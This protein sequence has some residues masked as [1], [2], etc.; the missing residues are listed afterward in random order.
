MVAFTAHVIAHVNT[1]FGSSIISLMITPVTRP[2]NSPA[3]IV[4]VHPVAT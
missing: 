4:K 3:G 2:D 1:S